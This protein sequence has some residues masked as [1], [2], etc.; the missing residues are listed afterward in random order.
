MKLG[1]IRKYLLIFESDDDSSDD[2]SNDSDDSGDSN[3]SEDR[4]TFFW[5]IGF[6]TL[7]HMGMIE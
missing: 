2:D 5:K 3:D 4:D 6:L 1:V 7:W